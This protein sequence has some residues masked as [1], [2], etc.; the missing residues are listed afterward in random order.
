MDSTAW[1]VG[2]IDQNGP[3]AGCDRGSDIVPADPEIAPDC[4][5]DRDTP[6][7]ENV[8]NIAIVGGL[9]HDHFV[10][11][12][13]AAKNRIKDR[14]RRTSRDGDLAIPVVMRAVKVRNLVGNC[15]AQ[16]GH[17]SHRRV[18]IEPVLHRL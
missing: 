11:W 7:H 4:N 1:V 6:S 3:R 9:D 17:P 13:D 2:R 8:R 15:L 16:S 10:A 18:L 5:R 12:T 14:L